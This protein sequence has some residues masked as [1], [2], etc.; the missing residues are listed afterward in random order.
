MLNVDNSEEVI[1][2]VPEFVITVD[3]LLAIENKRVLA[4]YMVWRIVLQSISSLDKKYR[5]I[6]LNY[7]KILNGLNQQPPRFL[8]CLSRIEHW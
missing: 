7:K 6:Y 1:V 3:K 2:T 4:N 8:T 5:E